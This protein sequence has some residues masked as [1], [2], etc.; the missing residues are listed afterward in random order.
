M[1]MTTDQ[2]KHTDLAQSDTP[3]VEVL[4][5]KTLLLTYLK[6]LYNIANNNNDLATSLNKNKT[7]QK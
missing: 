4:T 2:E 1:H 7:Q 3:A 5:T 6:H